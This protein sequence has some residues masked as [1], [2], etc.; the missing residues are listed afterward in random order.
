[1]QAAMFFSFGERHSYETQHAGSVAVVWFV[2]CC[3]V[4]ARSYSCVTGT[5]SR[6]ASGNWALV[7]RKVEMRLR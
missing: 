7:T 2:R 3:V 1:M 5:M 6:M 4:G